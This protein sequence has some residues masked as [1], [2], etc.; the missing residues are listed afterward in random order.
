M[1]LAFGSMIVAGLLA[2][3]SNAD[4]QN[5]GFAVN[6]FEPSERGS[7][8]FVLESLDFR[9]NTRPALGVVGDYQ[10]KPLVIYNTDGSERAAV[11]KHML[12]THVGG[13]IVLGETI[14]LSVNMPFVPYVEGEQ[15]RL[16]GVTYNPPATEN[17]AGDLRFA[18]DVKLF[19]QGEDA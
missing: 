1:R 16:R 10:Y 2:A 5:A 8:W 19:G 4:A 3:T 7:H 14:R 13:S 17:T 18:F 11:V 12:T 9:G 6:R 15:G